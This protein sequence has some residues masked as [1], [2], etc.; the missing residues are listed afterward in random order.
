M[1]SSPSKFRVVWALSLVGF[2]PLIA[3]QVI[4]M[5]RY[6]LFS[7]EPGSAPHNFGFNVG[8]YF[9]A[10]ILSILILLASVFIYIAR[11]YDLKK[12]GYKLSTSDRLSVL[13]A[14]ILLILIF[15]GALLVVWL[16]LKQH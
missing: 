15:V 16:S 3:A 5:F 13:P 14:A 12:A 8:F 7:I 1:M 4:S 10:H 11:S 2:L 9:P 6:Q